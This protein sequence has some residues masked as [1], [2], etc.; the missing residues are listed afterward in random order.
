MKIQKDDMQLSIGSCLPMQSKKFK[1]HL[2]LG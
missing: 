2:I 1:L